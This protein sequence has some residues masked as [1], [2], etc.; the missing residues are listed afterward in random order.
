VE[1]DANA[2]V[3]CTVIVFVNQDVTSRCNR[4]HSKLGNTLGMSVIL[5]AFH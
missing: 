3:A 4:F 5:I 2:Q 1:A